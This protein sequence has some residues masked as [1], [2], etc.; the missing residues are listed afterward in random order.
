MT[1]IDQI[2]Q[3]VAPILKN[4]AQEQLELSQA[5]QRDFEEQQAKIE[6]LR[7]DKLIEQDLERLRNK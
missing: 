3:H 2:I 7:I 5:I 4:Y 1:N 6:K